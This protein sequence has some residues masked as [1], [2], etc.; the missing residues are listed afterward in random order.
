MICL[1]DMSAN[2]GQSD[3]RASRKP[4]LPY[5]DGDRGDLTLGR[6]PS[7]KWQEFPQLQ[8]KLDAPVCVFVIQIPTL[9]LF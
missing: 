8:V 9:K 3:A 6:A 5:R 4:A 2:K 7:L 1:L